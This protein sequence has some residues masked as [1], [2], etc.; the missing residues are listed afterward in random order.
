MSSQDL[1]KALQNEKNEDL[2]KYTIKKIN[3]IK[4]KVITNL[5]IYKKDKDLLKKT[6]KADVS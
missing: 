4:N 5:P 3:D 6:K 2:F 1:L